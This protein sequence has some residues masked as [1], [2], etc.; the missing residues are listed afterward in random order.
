MCTD[1]LRPRTSGENDNKVGS[2]RMAG[3]NAVGT[4][5]SALQRSTSPGVGLA[6]ASA[7]G[8]G[9][10]PEL[11]TLAAERVA[12]RV[13]GKSLVSPPPPEHPPLSTARTIGII[14]VATAA[15]SLSGAGTMSLSI[16]LPAIM[17]DLQIPES[18]LQWISSAFSLT[19]G[20]FLLLAGRLADVYGRKMVFVVGILWNAIWNL[21]G[22]FMKNTA[23]L[24][25][26][27]ALA[28]VG[29]AACIPAGIGIIAAT[30]SGRTRSSAFAA[31]SAGGPIG[32]GLGL[33][34]GG[35]LTAYTDQSWRAALWCFGAIAFLVA[36]I[37]YFV[38]IPDR[39]LDTDRRVDWV[40]AGIITVGLV[41]LQFS[42]S[43][44]ESAPNGW[45]TGCE[46][47]LGR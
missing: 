17:T 10:T 13:S 42:I 36:A 22:G 34:V 28:G 6:A 43:D 18:Q 47:P 26:T 11:A 14:V 20:C 39:H 40:G 9:A 24:V 1:E 31:F 44:A 5:S 8:A 2:A 7:D 41:L 27:R 23:A 3:E 25:V 16:A 33:I 15:M 19:N 4:A 37:G 45:K 12:S 46:L 32:G 38:V 29:S 21:V 30:F 35:L